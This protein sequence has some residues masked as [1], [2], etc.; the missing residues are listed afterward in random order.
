MR[1]AI[2]G[3]TGFIGSHC[4]AQAVAAGHQVRMLIRNP[5]KARATLEL[6]ELTPDAVEVVE[7]D[8]RDH[9]ALR[10]GLI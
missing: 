1:G 8:L 2:T 5:S 3:G 7:A 9:P 10:T 6:H 4:V